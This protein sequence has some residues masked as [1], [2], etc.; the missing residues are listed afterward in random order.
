MTVPFLRDFP[1][2]TSQ[3]SLANQLLI[4]K[5]M[6]NR[7]CQQTKDT[8]KLFITI[9][10]LSPMVGLLVTLSIMVVPAAVAGSPRNHQQ[11]SHPPSPDHPSAVRR[12]A[13]PSTWD[14]DNKSQGPELNADRNCGKRGW[15][16]MGFSHGIG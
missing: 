3:A 9:T 12:A 4:K 8:S 16:Q 1:W 5:L 7:G 14:S 10:Q 2:A 15:T 6:N 11:N 13:A